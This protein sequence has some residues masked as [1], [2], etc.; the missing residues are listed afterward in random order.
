MEN[1]WYTSMENCREAKGMKGLYQKYFLD[2]PADVNETYFQHW[3]QAI[4]TGT[5]MILA[6]L[7]AIVHGFIPGVFTTTASDFARLVVNNVDARK[8]RAPKPGIHI[9]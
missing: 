6:G 1:G 8:D 3:R 2:H 5:N 7:A 9:Y 4:W